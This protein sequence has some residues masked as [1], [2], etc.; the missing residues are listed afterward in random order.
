MLALFLAEEAC[1]VKIGCRQLIVSSATFNG[2]EH[3][4]H[5]GIS[6]V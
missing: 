3:H 1:L 5:R 4:L 2:E 6:A